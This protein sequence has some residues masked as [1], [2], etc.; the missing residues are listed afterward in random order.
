MK[1][2]KRF[3]LTLIQLTIGMV[4][5][6]IL[7]YQ[8]DVSS[9]FKILLKADLRL[10]IAA[11]F[12]IIAASMMIALSFFFI[13]SSLK[14]RVSLL[15]CFQANFAGQLAS[16]LTPGRAGYFITPFVM[17]F[18]SNTPF[19]ACLVATMVSG[20]VD[21]FIRA[22]LTVLS[23]A[24]LISPIESI[25]GVQW[26]VFTSALI[27][28][29]SAISFGVLLWSEKPRKLLL[30]FGSFKKIGRFIDPYIKQF[31]DFQ[32]E[33]AKARKSLIPVFLAMLLTCVLDSMALFFFSLSVGVKLPPILFVFIYSLV[34]SFTYLPFTLAGLGV[35]ESIL[36]AILQLFGV[37]LA[38]SLSISLLFRFFY[39]VTD[40][41]GLPGILKIGLSRVLESTGIKKES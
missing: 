3:F 34:S 31:E 21:F 30:K 14:Y 35:Q 37:S 33:G 38:H 17:A 19:K 18:L 22:V 24:F 12:L 13:M 7:L 6:A 40:F 23:V 39:T 25:S 36:A 16:D 10:V 26:V 20:M 11:S 29:V 8:A 2:I 27:L 28:A 9:T 41:I 32:R 5:I 4:I 15:S 1:I